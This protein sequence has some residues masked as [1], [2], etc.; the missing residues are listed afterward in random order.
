MLARSDPAFLSRIRD[1]LYV[2]VL[3]DVLDEVG[4]RDQALPPRI[5]P[6]DESLVM[7]G[8]ARTGLYRDVYHVAP[9]VNPYEL[10]IALIDSLE[11]GEVPVL[12]CG[13][14]GR[15]A[16]WGELLS[17]ASR[18][19]SA[20]GCL[21]DG[22]VRDI[23]AIR[24]MGFPVF[25]GGIGPLDSKGRGM[26]VEIDGPVECAGVRVE[27]GDLV[28]GDADGV[29]VVPRAVEDEVLARAFAKVEGEDRTRADLERGDT[30]AEVFARYGIL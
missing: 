30:L 27:S 4:H 28:V 1:T 12:A 3:S 9:G 23:K 26:V 6:L 19:R 2:A 18:A 7:A 11:P 10:E 25:H 17:T 21:T 16:P 20:A 29:V 13:A 15:I 8:F 24:R 14:S 22:L 5:R